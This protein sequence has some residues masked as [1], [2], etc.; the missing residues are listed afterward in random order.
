[1]NHLKQIAARLDEYGID[2][3]LVSS[4]PGERYA[5]GFKGEGYVV[6]AKNECRYFTDSRYIEAAEKQVTGTSVT[7]TD[8]AKNYRILI[9]KAVDDLGVEKL[10][11][12]DGY[13][14][15]AQYRQLADAFTCELVPAQGLL[16]ALRAAKDE[17]EIALM[18]KAQRISEQALK[19][20]LKFLRPG[21][22]EK[23]VAA[24]LTYDML[25]FGA[26]K[27][28][29]DP[30]VASGPNGS[31]PHAVPSDRAI[32]SG[33]F[34]TMDFGCVYGGY[35]SDM[36]RTVAVGEPTEEMK[37][38]YAVVLEAQLAGIAAEKA[39]VTGKSV[40]AAARRVI[41]DAGYGEYFGH[42]FG[43][44]VGLEIHEAPNAGSTCEDV[45]PL[46]AAVS[47]EPGIYLPGK[48]GV[49]IEDVTIFTAD[50]CVNLTKAPKDLIIL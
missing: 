39:G 18:T 14:T 12:E 26:E 4:E 27:M 15:V 43:H 7:M 30:I 10:G 44:S 37:K 1:M 3:M 42:S 9:Q 21:V 19:E 8:R 50:G 48:F 24:K 49:R 20:I 23:E 47:A 6:V 45:I 28:S 46:G 33:E 41:E 22:T 2:A 29:F 38:V 16:G 13:M 34:V 40:D 5:V 36:T 31:L 25:R 17:E 35:C 32:Q 11:F